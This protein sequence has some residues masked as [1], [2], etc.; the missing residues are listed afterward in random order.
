MICYPCSIEKVSFNFLWN[1]LIFLN[2]FD[3][4]TI[5]DG[6]DL[7]GW[8]NNIIFLN[9]PVQSLN[10]CTEKEYI[11]QIISFTCY[12]YDEK[13]VIEKLDTFI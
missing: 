2:K 12:S 7:F 6:K 11:G 5:I 3:R 4:N 8:I 9:R 13:D 1:H 10:F